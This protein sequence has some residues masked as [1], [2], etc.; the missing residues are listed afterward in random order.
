MYDPIHRKCPN[1]QIRQESWY[2]GGCV[3]FAEE[4]EVMPMSQ[5]FFGDSGICG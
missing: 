3:E 1:G 5:G 4:I 2:T